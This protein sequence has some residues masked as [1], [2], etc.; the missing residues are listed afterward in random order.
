MRVGHQPTEDLFQVGRILLA[1][2]SQCRGD[3]DRLC[4]HGGSSFLTK[5]ENT[6]WLEEYKVDLEKELVG[7]S[8]RIHELKH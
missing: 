6:E 3:I 4:G 2:R 1:C 7:V 5:Q 8:E